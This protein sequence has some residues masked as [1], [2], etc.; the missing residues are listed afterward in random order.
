VVT[1][2]LEDDGEGRVEV[3]EDGGGG[4]GFLEEG[5]YTLAP[6]VPVP[7]GV[8]PHEP[9]EEFGDPGVVINELAVEISKI[10]EGLHF[11]YTPGWRPV[12]DGF[13]LSRVHANAVQSDYD[14]EVL[15]FGGV[16][17]ALLQLG[18]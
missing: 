10:K 5:E 8:L 11:F 18:M 15:D 14:T 7:W 2:T 17:Q 9:V 16:E 4:E 6:A 12:E 1:V 3:V 13:H